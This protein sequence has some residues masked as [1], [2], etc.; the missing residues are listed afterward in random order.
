MY[1]LAAVLAKVVMHEKAVCH[2]VTD[3]RAAGMV[4]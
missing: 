2:V 3:D 4:P 1:R